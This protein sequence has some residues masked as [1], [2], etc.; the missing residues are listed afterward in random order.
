MYYL[1][2]FNRNVLIF[3]FADGFYYGGY[4]VINAFL[5]VLITAKITDGRVDIASY[6]IAYYLILRA[7]AELPFS[8]FVR[9]L[10]DKRKVEI[11]A[12]LY[13]VYGILVLLMGFS[14]MVW[15]IF[16]LQTFIALID[17]FSYPIRWPMFTRIVDRGNE[18]L[19]W[20]VEDIAGT[21]LPAV[22]SALAGVVAEAWGVS[23]AF[24][25]FGP[26]FMVSGISF[27]LIDL[28]RHPHR[29]KTPEHAREALEWIVGH[30][31]AIKARFEITGGLAAELHGS[32]RPLADI[33]IDVH[34]KTLEKLLPRIHEYV[35]FG[36]A[37]YQDATWDLRLL[38]LRYKTQLI[39]LCGIEHTKVY[40]AERHEWTPEVNDFSKSV[41]KELFGMRLP[42]ATKHELL[43]YKSKTGKLVD[44][45]DVAQ[46]EAHKG[47]PNE[48]IYSELANEPQVR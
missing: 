3:I 9:R 6:V 45:I 17:A 36:P 19:E 5:S 22:F 26:V 38:T 4:S 35:I 14:S 1:R 10:S 33:D 2:L 43:E 32:R 15:E 8:N 7:I 20:G 46:M 42:V 12:T 48:H 16:A 28:S 34:E 31:R 18:E 40:D 13:V 30:L 41:T 39:D 27:A 23:A 21:I 11:V 44:T 47:G 25:V 29:P 24:Y 37:R